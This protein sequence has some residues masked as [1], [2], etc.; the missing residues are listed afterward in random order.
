MLTS[1]F[2]HYDYNSS[3]IFLSEILEILFWIA[4]LM[5]CSGSLN[6]TTLISSLDLRLF[7][8]SDFSWTARA[9]FLCFASARS[10]YSF[11]SNSTFPQVCLSTFASVA[12]T[13]SFFFPVPVLYSFGTIKHDFLMV[14]NQDFYIYYIHHIIIIEVSG[15]HMI[16]MLYL[17]LLLSLNELLK[18]ISDFL[19]SNFHYK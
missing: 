16:I 11:V 10:A 12:S 18:G 9:V 14:S 7:K 1:S 17:Q 3:T 2:I 5:S 15:H 4:L 13:L 6:A 19:L 8:F